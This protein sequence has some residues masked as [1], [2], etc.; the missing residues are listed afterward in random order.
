MSNYN[1]VGPHYV[2]NLHDRHALQLLLFGH[3]FSLL[4]PHIE[5]LTNGFL[6]KKC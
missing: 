1:A 6:A 5:F 2:A 4:I 3:I